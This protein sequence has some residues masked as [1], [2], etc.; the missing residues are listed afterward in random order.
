[1]HP[2]TNDLTNKVFN[3][4]TVLYSVDKPDTVNT[5][6]RGVWWLCKCICNNIKIVRSA[7]LIRG[8]TK[9]CGCMKKFFNSKKYKG[10]GLLAQS[11]FSHIEY[12]A[13]K[14]NL[15]FSVTKEY[16]WELYLYQN[17]KCYYTDLDIDLNTRNYKKTASIDRIDSSKGYIENNVV[18][19]HKNINIM[20]NVFSEKQFI[21]YCKLIVNKHCPYDP[22]QEEGNTE[23]KK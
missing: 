3:S 12:G 6:S 23:L 19:V 9:S 15:E 1:M 8:D 13:K 20:K 21:N 14:R 7:E 2:N 18:W 17:G 10:T 16:L 22:P 11:V 4:L 5:K